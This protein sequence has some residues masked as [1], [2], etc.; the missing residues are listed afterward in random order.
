MVQ[1]ILIPKAARG[2]KDE[3]AIWL[4]RQRISAVGGFISIAV[5]ALL[6]LGLEL[7]L[8]FLADFD[9][10][11]CAY[12]FVRVIIWI[13][14]AIGIYKLIK[15]A[16]ERRALRILG[17]DVRVLPESQD[18]RS[19]EQRRDERRWIIAIVIWGFGCFILLLLWDTQKSIPSPLGDWIAFAIYV[20]G[21]FYFLAIWPIRSWVDRLLGNEKRLKK[22]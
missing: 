2:R 14:S 9:R 20:V 19:R 13:G 8:H 15:P 18:D 6:T 22:R 10:D 11:S 16:L 17:V 21:F 12:S 3:G 4:V 1:W 7:G 5:G